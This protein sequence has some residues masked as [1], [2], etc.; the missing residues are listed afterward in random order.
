MNFR[1]PGSRRAIEF[2][3]D[4]TNLVDIAFLLIIFFTLST[5]FAPSVKGGPGINVD[6]PKASSKDIDK[7]KK[8]VV[9]TLTKDGLTIL[10]GKTISPQEVESALREVSRSSED[11]LLIVQADKNVPHGRVVS[12]MDIAKGL[13]INRLAIATEEK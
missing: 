11:V 5:S 6:L 7:G 8:T 12:I 3:I 9:M 10:A 4:V 13:G 2:R 1:G